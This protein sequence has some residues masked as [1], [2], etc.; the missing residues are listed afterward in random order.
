M[1]EILTPQ[2]LRWN[3]FADAL[4]EALTEGLDEGL[5]GRCEGD[6]GQAGDRAH[7]CAKH[8]MRRMQDVDIEG[9]LAFFQQ[10]GGYC[11]CEILLNVDA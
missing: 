11:D 2:S 3:E 1:L 5:P 10:H 6:H 9:S 8:V 7:G 4:N